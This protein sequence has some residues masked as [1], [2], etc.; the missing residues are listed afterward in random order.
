MNN[1]Q[2]FLASIGLGLVFSMLYGSFY[3]DSANENQNRNKEVSKFV[4][5]QILLGLPHM[6][7]TKFMNDSNRVQ[8]ADGMIL[9]SSYFKTQDRY[10]QKITMTYS[11]LIQQTESGWSLLILKLNNKLVK[12]GQH[13]LRNNRG[14]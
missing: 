7:E 11:A 12:L 2:V 5:E 8:E 10:G 13:S 9:L 1:K 6:A 14:Y 3:S 4:H